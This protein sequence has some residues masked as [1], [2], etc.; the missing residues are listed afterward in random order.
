VCGTT[1]GGGGTEKC[2][3]FRVSK[4]CLLVLLVDVPLRE[5]K[6]LGSEESKVFGNGLCYEQTKEFEQGV[7]CI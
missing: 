5:G 7:Y 4:E 3:A 1:L 6:A 2:S